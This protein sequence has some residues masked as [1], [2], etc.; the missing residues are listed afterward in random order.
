[1]SN[2]TDKWLNKNEK[3]F[4]EDCVKI[5][6]LLSAPEPKTEE[7]AL[8]YSS[9]VAGWENKYGS[10]VINTIEQLVYGIDSEILDQIAG[11]D[12]ELDEEE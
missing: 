1:M 7:E 4:S 5:I 10:E 12:I 9:A 3:R 8:A 2:A 11:E 6:H